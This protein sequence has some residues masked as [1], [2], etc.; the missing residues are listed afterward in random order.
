MCEENT[1]KGY[2][3]LVAWD[4]NGV[5]DLINNALKATETNMKIS[6]LRLRPAGH[7]FS[8]SPDVFIGRKIPEQ[9]ASQ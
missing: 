9:T 4:L 1:P 5:E 3:R 8:V 6:I 7:N 2:W